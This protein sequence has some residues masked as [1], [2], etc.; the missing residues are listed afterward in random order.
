MAKHYSYIRDPATI[1]KMS[2]EAIEKATDLSAIPEDM[3][4]IAI[5]L[6]HACGMPE[7]L[8]DLAYSREAYAEGRAALRKG[9]AILADSRMVVDGII[10]PRLPARN[11]VIT[12]INEPRVIDTAQTR[13]ITRSAAGVEMWQSYLQGAVVA[14][15]NAPTALFRLLELLGDGAP[16]PA[17]IIGMP[18]GFVGAAEAKEQLIADAGLI[19]YITLRGRF[20]GS[21]L[22][23]AVVNALVGDLVSDEPSA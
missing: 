23:A 20:G 17:L 18:V 6:V 13:R 19:P 7:I 11:H 9:A 8:R 15:G 5:R 10:R 12:T 14:I 2:Q 1:Y 4:P 16:K 21:A 3:R 22:A